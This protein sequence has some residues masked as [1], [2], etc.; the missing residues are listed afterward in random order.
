MPK[1][2]GMKIS[3]EIPKVASKEIFWIIAPA[4]VWLK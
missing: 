4:I 3:A 2:I 1:R